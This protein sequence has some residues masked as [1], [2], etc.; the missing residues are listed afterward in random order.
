MQ[1]HMG[2]PWLLISTPN[3]VRTPAPLLEQDTDQV[4]HDTLGY[5]AQQIARLKE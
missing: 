1:T 3:D 4:M 2:M 5:S